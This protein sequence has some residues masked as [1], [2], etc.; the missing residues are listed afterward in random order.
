[1][2]KTTLWVW[3]KKVSFQEPGSDLP[4]EVVTGQ[5]VLDLPLER[6]VADTKRDVAELLKR[7]KEAVGRV[8]KPRNVSHNAAVVAGTRIPVRAIQHFA[9]GGYSV[10]QI[11]KEYP[12]VTKETCARP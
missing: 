2:T 1:M 9:D 10:Q 8:G 4:R 7:P 12:S 3:E 6:V 5:Y 11:L